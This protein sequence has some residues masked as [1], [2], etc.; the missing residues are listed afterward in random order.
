MS[1]L[2]AGVDTNQMDAM[3]VSVSSELLKK[4]SRA[5]TTAANPIN[6]RLLLAAVV[7]AL[8]VS[9]VILMRPRRT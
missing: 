3:F 2:T 4:T 8:D 9:S 6:V 5:S 1:K 7:D